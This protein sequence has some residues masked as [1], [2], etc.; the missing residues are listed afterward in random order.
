MLGGVCANGK[1]YGNCWAIR[2]AAAV[3]DGWRCVLTRTGRDFMR[4]IAGCAELYVNSTDT[5]CEIRSAK[6][7][8]IWITDAAASWKSGRANYAN[9][10]TRTHS[11]QILGQTKHF[12]ICGSWRGAGTGLCLDT[13]YSPPRN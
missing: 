10:E 9:D 12:A 8:A 13:E 7:N 6:R 4:R 5:G 11:A 2:G 1:V 3:F